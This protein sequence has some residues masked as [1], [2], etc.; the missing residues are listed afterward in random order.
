MAASC[1]ESTCYLV[2]AILPAVA[3]HLLLCCHALSLALQP[4][5]RDSGVTWIK[6]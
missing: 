4:A 1:H 5:E 3:T 6:S 2:L